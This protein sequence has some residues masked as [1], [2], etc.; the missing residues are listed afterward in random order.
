MNKKFKQDLI[1]FYGLYIIYMHHTAHI[2]E[3]NFF[4]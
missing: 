1:K 3:T 4:A 2:N